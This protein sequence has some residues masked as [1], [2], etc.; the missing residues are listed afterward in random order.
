MYKKEHHYNCINCGN[1]FKSVRTLK[2]C[3]CGFSPIIDLS[4]EQYNYEKV[5]GEKYGFNSIPRRVST[6]ML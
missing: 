1:K 3:Y 6:C 4:E 2:K 5:K